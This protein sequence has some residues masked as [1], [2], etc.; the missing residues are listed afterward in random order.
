MDNNHNNGLITKIWG[1]HLWDSLHCISFGYPINPTDED[2]LHYKNF[3]LSLGYVLPCKY[4]KESYLYF[5]NTEPTIIDD[6]VFSSRN[7]L[8]KW[9][10]ELH[11]R[12][13]QKLGIDY[14]I[15]YEDVVS[16]Y[17][18]YRARCLPNV[19]GCIMPANMK[20]K[21][22]QNNR[23]K[24]CSIINIKYALALKPYAE[25]RG[26]NFDHIEYFDKLKT[27]KKSNEWLDRNEQCQQIMYKMHCDGISSIE[28]DG[29]YKGFPSIEELKLISMLCSNLSKSELSIVAHNLNNPVKNKYKLKVA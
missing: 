26:V 3:F 19:A 12:V 17:E 7:N 8:T 27:N 2:K 13:N 21:S 6:H 11:E 16:K 15:N 22:Y 1:P 24:D 5:I 10:Y 18:S 14:G 20:A 23:K 4:C 25:K 29:A 28:M 9:L